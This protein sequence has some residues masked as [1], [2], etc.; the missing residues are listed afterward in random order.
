MVDKTNS[1]RRESMDFIVDDEVDVDVVLMVMV[2]V[3]VM[4]LVWG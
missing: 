4:V 3:M 1:V 2:M